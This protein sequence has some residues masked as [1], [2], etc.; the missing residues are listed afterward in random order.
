MGTY[1]PQFYRNVFSYSCTM[2]MYSLLVTPAQKKA[3]WVMKSQE[4]DTQVRHADCSIVYWCIAEGV[5]LSLW[6]KL[7][8]STSNLEWCHVHFS[9]DSYSTFIRRIIGLGKNSVELFFDTKFDFKPTWNRDSV[10][11][12]LCVP[13]RLLTTG[14]GVLG[15]CDVDE[16]IIWIN[17]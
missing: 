1:I 12:G 5:P 10:T 17:N 15:Q 16:T 4:H 14:T 13:C 11:S 8:S 7:T 3:W 2:Y 9:R 6:K